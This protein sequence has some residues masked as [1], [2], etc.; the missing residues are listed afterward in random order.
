MNFEEKAWYLSKT[1]WAGFLAVIASVLQALGVV[2]L[3]AG[4]VEEFSTLIPEII[5]AVLTAIAGLGAIYGRI[6]ADRK[7]E[8]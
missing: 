2:E 5:A 1:I 3:G 8:G 6:K 7:I 4:D